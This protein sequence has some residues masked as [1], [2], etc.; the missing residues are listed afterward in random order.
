MRYN[1]EKSSLLS[2]V[3]GRA[4]WLD[5]KIDL[6]LDELANGDVIVLSEFSRVAEID[7]GN[8]NHQQHAY[9]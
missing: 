6:I 3:S 1:L 4:S 2:K 7:S 9:N 8:I 5:H